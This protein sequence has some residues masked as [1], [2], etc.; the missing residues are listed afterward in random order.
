[1]GYLRNTWYVAAWAH[2]IRP[3]RSVGIQILGEPIVI[4]RTAAGVLSAFEDRCIHRLAPLS[5]GRCEGERL[6]CMYHGLLYDRNGRVVEI[7]GQD[8]I[9]S[10][11]RVRTYPIVE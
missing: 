2:E 11:W 7:P 1:M 4:W 10:D 3:E 8:R 9:T 5:M 6:R